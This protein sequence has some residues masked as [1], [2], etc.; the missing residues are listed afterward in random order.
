ML[1]MEAAKLEAGTG[2]CNP[3]DVEATKTTEPS[4]GAEK[5]H[6]A[7]KGARP[8][9]VV[10]TAEVVVVAVPGVLTDEGS[11]VAPPAGQPPDDARVGA[12]QWLSEMEKKQTLQE[13]CA[14]EAAASAPP[15]DQ[16]QRQRTRYIGPPD[17]SRRN[18][19]DGLQEESPDH[20]R[21]ASA[22]HHRRPT[23]PGLQ[24]GG[25]TRAPREGEHQRSPRRRSSA[26]GEGQLSSSPERRH[27]RSP[28]RGEGHTSSSPDRRMSSSPQQRLRDPGGER[29]LERHG[30][31]RD[32]NGDRGAA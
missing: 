31:R 4:S 14:T 27:R 23:A 25:Q 28:V 21:K 17:G 24:E 32:A 19:N 18:L 1:S 29:T 26:H 20:R 9:P 2:T 6:G 3:T 22:S 10:E 12:R 7:V 11:A 15:T 16:A 5:A 30:S 8:S 13:S